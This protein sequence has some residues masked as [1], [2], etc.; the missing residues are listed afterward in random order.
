MSQTVTTVLSDLQKQDLVHM[1][2]GSILIRN[3]EQL[4]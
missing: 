2:R 4:K 3:L 1:E